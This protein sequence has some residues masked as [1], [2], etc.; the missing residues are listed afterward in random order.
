MRFRWPL[1]IAAVL[2]VASAAWPWMHIGSELMPRLDEGD[3]LYMPTTD[4][5][6]SITEARQVLQQ[7]DKLLMTFP[8]VISVDGK[9]GRAE[10]ATDPAP[11]DMIETVVRLQT[12]PAKWR[13]R[14]FHHWFDGAPR[15]LTWPLRRTFWPDTQPI[16]MDE[17]VYGWSD[18]DGTHHPGMNDV[19]SFPGV[20]NAWPMPIENRTNMLSTGIK[21]PVGIKIMGPDLAELSK[22]A[23]R[24]AI[25]MHAIPGTTSA[26]AE[27]T[28]GGYYLD[29]DPRPEQI[30]RYGLNTGDVQDVIE[31][32]I[33]GMRVATT[34]QGLERYPINVRYARDLRDDPYQIKQLLVSTPTGA[35]I[36]IGQLADIRIR[37]GAPMIRSENTR[38]S[39]WVYVDMTG[40]DMG[41]YMADARRAMQQQ[42]VLPEG[43][44]LEWSGQYAIMQQNAIRWKVAG[45]IALLVIILLLYAASQSWLRTIIVLLAVPFSIVGAMW[46]LWLLEY[47]WSGA[48]IV[49][50]IALAGLDAETGIVMLLYLDNSFERFKAEGR[51]TGDRDLREAIQ[52]GAVKRIRPKTMTVAAAFI[53]LVPLLWASG[54]GADVMRRIAAPMLGGLFTSF[55]MELLIYPVIFYIA[56]S[57]TLSSDSDATAAGQSGPIQGRNGGDGDVSHA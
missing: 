48:V 32:A 14:T 42:L 19:V 13:K 21:T 17:L 38:Q 53:G 52:D 40:R 44:T 10:T 45:G 34:V 7:T 29:I 18:A 54:T 1:M 47:N 12:D 36:P 22:L 25:I 37:P 33:G 41:S 16:S 20:E 2:F 8:E 30:A 28:M 31:T 24:A 27:R 35:Q 5:S 55:L 39:A 43:Y 50:L 4:P 49:G 51:M 9:I 57:A 6:I 56:K 23:E 26:Y 11:L 3:L 15:W 46:F